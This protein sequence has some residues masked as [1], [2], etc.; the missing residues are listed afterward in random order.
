VTIPFAWRRVLWPFLKA[1]PALSTI[2]IILGG[3]LGGAFTPTEASSVAVFYGL[4]LAFVVYRSL[5]FKQF[6]ALFHHHRDQRHGAA[7]H[8]H[9]RDARLR[10]DHL[11]SAGR[12]RQ[13]A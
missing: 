5:T 8:R 3:V 2:A 10:G 4:F 9:G 7:R 11:S 13:T 12:A 1:V 6:F